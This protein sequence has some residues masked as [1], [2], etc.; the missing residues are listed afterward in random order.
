MSNIIQW[1]FTDPVTAESN[2]SNAPSGAA[3]PFHF[4]VPWII[5]CVLGL[6]IWA[7]YWLEGR[8]RF[9]GGHALNKYV[10]DKITNQLA[11]FS[12]VAF[13]I[14]FGR[15][16]LDNTFFADRFWRYAWLAWGVGYLVYWGY[17]FAFKYP[18][19]LRDYR[20]RRTMEKY[21]PQPKHKKAKTA[22]A[23]TR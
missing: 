21:I 22:R 2:V 8:R 10:L 23:A 14:M 13:F 6:V 4:W 19:M 17:F 18:D 9:F 5:F 12:F 20:R 15:W 16:A 3:E 11:L 1:L 7:Y